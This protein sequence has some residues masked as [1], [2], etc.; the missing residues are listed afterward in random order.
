[1]CTPLGPHSSCCV[2]QGRSAIRR[3][4]SSCGIPVASVDSIAYGIG[5][6]QWRRTKCSSATVQPLIGLMMYDWIDAL[7][8]PQCDWLVALS[9]P[10]TVGRLSTV[11]CC[12]LLWD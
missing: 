10:T 12:A 2:R 4:T 5:T 3:V 7:G 11:R 9:P 6:A 1:M 8:R